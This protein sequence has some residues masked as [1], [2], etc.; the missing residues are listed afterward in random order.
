MLRAILLAILAFP[1]FHEDAQTDEKRAQLEAIAGAV[2]SV[3]KT[4]DEAAFL[5]AWGNA[6]SNFSLRIHRGDCNH[7]EC[8]GG[9]ARG[10]W[11]AHKNG[12]PDERW[13]KMVGIENV[14]VQAEQA[15]RHARWALQACPQNRIRGAFRVL[16][17]RGCSSPIKGEN[18]RFSTFRWVRGLLGAGV[19]SS[20][21]TATA[22][23]VSHAE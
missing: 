12:M 17:G 13:E 4:P 1:V 18:E 19:R 11:Q 5:L 8:D 21:R 7:W 14:D 23:S 10:P 3:A 2:A 15:I 16:A 9:R 20:A 6:E 22:T